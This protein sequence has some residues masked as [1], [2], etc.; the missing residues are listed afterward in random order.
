MQATITKLC[1]SQGRGTSWKVE[2]GLSHTRFF[3]I[4]TPKTHLIQ[5]AQDNGAENIKFLTTGR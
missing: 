3:P 1:D 5:C 4:G 2:V